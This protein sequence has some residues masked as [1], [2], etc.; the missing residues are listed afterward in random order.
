MREPIGITFTGPDQ[1]DPVPVFEA[2]GGVGA[3]ERDGPYLLS[4]GKSL[5]D[6]IPVVD[7]GGPIW[8]DR[9]G[10]LVDALAI[11]VGEGPEPPRFVRE[12]VSDSAKVVVAGHSFLMTPVG[13]YPGDDHGGILHSAWPGAPIPMDFVPG[14]SSTAAWQLNG[15]A[16][17]EPSYDV[18]IVTEIADVM[19]GFPAV[20]SPQGIQNLQHLYWFG[21]E[22]QARGAELVLYQPWSTVYADLDSTA[23]PIFNYYRQWLEQHLGQPVYVIPA[24]QYVRALRNE[25]GD[26]IFEDGVHL[27]RIDKWPRG[28]SYLVYS[29]LTKQRCPFVVEGDEDIDQMAWD[30]LQAEKWAGFG[31][32]VEVSPPEIDD[33]LPEP[34]T[35]TE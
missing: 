3:V 24:G 18:L 14:G 19:S 1:A 25:F 4:D 11:S 6:P 22:A 5:L 13:G 16:R 34:A 32:S 33:P 27:R 8:R 20:D 21:L 28:T 17:N 9:A 15:A 23:I 10:N 29:F 31:G 2:E 35:L 12:A 26:D 7:A 30:V